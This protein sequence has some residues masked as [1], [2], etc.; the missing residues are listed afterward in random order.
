LGARCS[1]KEVEDLVDSFN[2]PVL[3]FLIDRITKD[4]GVSLVKRLKE[5]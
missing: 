4:C 2:G 5:R 1:E 3:L